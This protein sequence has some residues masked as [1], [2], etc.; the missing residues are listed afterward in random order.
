MISLRFSSPTKPLGASYAEAVREKF[1]ASSKRVDVYPREYFNSIADVPDAA[2]P[3]VF[4]IPWKRTPS[5]KDVPRS[6][7]RQ[8]DVLPRALRELLRVSLGSNGELLASCYNK[9]KHG[10]Q[11][12]FCDPTETARRRGH[13]EEL[14]DNASPTIRLLLDGSRTQ[15]TQEES[16]RSERV[17]PFLYGDVDNAGRWLFQSLVLHSAHR[18]RGL[19][20]ISRACFTSGTRARRR[21]GARG[22]D[23]AAV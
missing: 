21:R 17:S 8:W 1:F 15:E 6:Q 13:R 7:R 4:G 11:L 19:A 22:P 9:M 5:V 23:A 16:A 3:A 18:G 14:I 12:I 20:L 10:P 2:L